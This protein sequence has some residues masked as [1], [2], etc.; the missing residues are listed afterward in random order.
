MGLGRNW[1]GGYGTPSNMPN[2]SVNFRNSGNLPPPPSYL[3]SPPRQPPPDVVQP[4]PQP[5]TQ[6]RARRPGSRRSNPWQGFDL[7]GVPQPPVAMPTLPPIVPPS[8]ATLNI[9]DEQ[10]LNRRRRISELNHR[11]EIYSAVLY[12]LAHS[13]DWQAEYKFIA[14][15]SASAQTQALLD[16][17]KLLIGAAGPLRYAI[18]A[19]GMNINALSKLLASRRAAR[20]STGP[21]P[22]LGRN[23]P[24]D[25][26]FAIGTSPAAVRLAL[27]TARPAPR[28]EPVEFSRG[29]VR[30]D[31][32]RRDGR[33]G[34]AR[35]LPRTGARGKGSAGFVRRWRAARRPQ[36]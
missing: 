22:R 35:P 24:C 9:I 15:D 19:R 36:P 8:V 2:F 32:R 20:W 14:E 7:R 30:A 31:L 27:P 5:S 26:A 1:G 13:M 23:P 34:V 21:P 3:Q 25:G 10:I 29:N 17:L 18:E 12:K 16:C 11:R 33:R 28:V 6:A 4:H